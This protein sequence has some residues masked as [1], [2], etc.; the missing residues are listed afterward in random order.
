MRTW[1][2]VNISSQR[3]KLFEGACE[4]VGVGEQAGT[5]GGAFQEGYQKVPC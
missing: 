3:G 5:A 1:G 4:Y 2:R